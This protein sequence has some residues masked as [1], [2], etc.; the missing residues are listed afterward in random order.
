MVGIG[1]TNM[2]SEYAL[3]AEQYDAIAMRHAVA[4]KKF[5]A[6]YLEFAEKFTAAVIEAKAVDAEA[7][8]I[9]SRKKGNSTDCP[10]CRR[11][12]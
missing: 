4:V 11:S 6:T 12:S 2:P 3:W 1:A 8:R 5:Q 7:Q 10:P 9:F